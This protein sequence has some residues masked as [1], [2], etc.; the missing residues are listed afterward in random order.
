MWLRQDRYVAG[1]LNLILGEEGVGKGALAAWTIAR[2]TKV[3]SPAP[4]SGNP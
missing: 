4:T 2:L 1:Y 3:S